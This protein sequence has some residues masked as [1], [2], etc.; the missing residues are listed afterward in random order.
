MS[1]LNNV[2]TALLEVIAGMKNGK[3]EVETDARNP[4]T[5]ILH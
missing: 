1:E 5:V 3:A 4:Y 2:D